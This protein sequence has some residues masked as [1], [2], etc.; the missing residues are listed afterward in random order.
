MVTKTNYDAVICL[1]AV[2]RD[3][4]PNFDSICA[5]V[6]KGVGQISLDSGIPIIFPYFNN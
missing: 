5:E 3:G 1:G 6:T 4:T 2:I